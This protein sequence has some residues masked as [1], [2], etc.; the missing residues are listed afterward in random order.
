MTVTAMV[1]GM[2]T[3]DCPYAIEGTVTQTEEIRACRVGL[4]R[5][6]SDVIAGRLRG[7]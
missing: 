5:A 2:K 6:S 7:L 1:F 4:V 3:A